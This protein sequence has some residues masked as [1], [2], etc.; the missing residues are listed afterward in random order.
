[1]TLPDA[2]V[3]VGLLMFASCFILALSR[4]QIAA[5]IEETKRLEAIMRESHDWKITWADGSATIKGK[6]KEA[7]Q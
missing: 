5:N 1:M 2:I 4:V 6:P 3:L 7:K